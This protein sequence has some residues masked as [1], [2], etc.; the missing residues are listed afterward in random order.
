[1]KMHSFKLASDNET[2]ILINRTTEKLV[3][4][5]NQHALISIVGD[6]DVTSTRSCC[7]NL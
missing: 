3:R 4:L 1:M 6:D 5:I 7:K 2:S